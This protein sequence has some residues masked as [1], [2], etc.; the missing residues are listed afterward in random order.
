M[1]NTSSAATS[2]QAVC[3]GDILLPNYLA[4]SVPFNMARLYHEFA[5]LYIHIYDTLLQSSAANFFE[6]LKFI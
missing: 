2:Y 6:T 1:P 5:H 4:Y 3:T